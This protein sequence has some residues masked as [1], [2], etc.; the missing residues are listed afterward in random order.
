[1]SDNA[2][3]RKEHRRVDILGCPFDA[4]TMAEVEQCIEDAI[5]RRE[6]LHITVGN[7]DMVMKARK[8]PRLA[9]AFWESQLTIVD[10]VPITWAAA[11]LR[12][13]V[14]GRVCG[15]DIVWRCAAISQKM[16]RGVALLGGGEGVAERA[17]TNLRKAYPNSILHVIPAPFPLRQE[18]TKRII[19]IIRANDDRIVLVALGAPRQEFWLNEH[20]SA[21]GAN[22]GIGI[23]A[24]FDI[25]SGSKPQAPEWM[26]RNG[27]EWFHRMR[28]EPRR[29][30]RRYLVEDMPFFGLLLKEWIKIALRRD[31]R[32]TDNRQFVNRIT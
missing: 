14:N 16:N 26:R 11:F 29:L 10:G 32:N 28:L 19:R 23:G 30:S 27:L 22:V 4:I 7:V 18:Y 13:S 8:D 1:M 5:R 6:Q 25:I 12:R 15:T 2:S 31:M 24:A 21:S 9:R 20:L 3:S 17:A